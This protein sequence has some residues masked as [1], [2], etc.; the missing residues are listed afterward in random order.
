MPPLMSDDASMY[1]GMHA[2]ME[3][4]SAAKLNTPQ[5]RRDIGT[6]ARSGF[7]RR[8]CAMSTS[9]SG[10][11]AARLEAVEFIENLFQATDGNR[12]SQMGNTLPQFESFL[13]VFQLCPSV[14]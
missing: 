9:T 4:Q 2:D 14:A 13:S 3:I 11:F 1:V 8:L 5:R 10:A 12:Y 6:G 7:R